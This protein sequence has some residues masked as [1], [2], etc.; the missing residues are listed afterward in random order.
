[1]GLVPESDLSWSSIAEISEFSRTVDDCVLEGDR[2]DVSTSTLAVPPSWLMVSKFS[3]PT[4]IKNAAEE[5]ETGPRISSIAVDSHRDN[6]HLT[7]ES[8]M[9]HAG[10]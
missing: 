1:S 10:R 2:L 7:C 5:A 9:F 4:L 6:I 8:S 3:G